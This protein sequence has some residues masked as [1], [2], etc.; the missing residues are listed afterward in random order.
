MYI[1]KFPGPLFEISSTQVFKRVLKKS[2]MKRYSLRFDHIFRIL[3]TFYEQWY[4]F[5]GP[6]KPFSSLNFEPKSQILVYS[7]K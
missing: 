3:D 4:M 5:Q 7:G 1:S 2:M 6:K